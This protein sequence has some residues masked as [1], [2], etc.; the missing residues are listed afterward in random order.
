[1]QEDPVS[2]L[3]VTTSSPA[4]TAAVAY[5][6]VCVHM[7]VCMHMC[8]YACMGVCVCVTET[9]MAYLSLYFYLI[10]QLMVSKHSVLE[11]CLPLG[12]GL[13]N[14]LPPAQGRAMCFIHALRSARSPGGG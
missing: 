6:N 3:I 7:Y 13:C 1:M 14:L 5:M 10:P 4:L 8:M 2:A 11:L 12:N 9:Y